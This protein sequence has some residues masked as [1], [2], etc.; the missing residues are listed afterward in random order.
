MIQRIQTIYLLLAFG[1]CLGCMCTTIG[2]LYTPNG[3]A[4]GK[5]FNLW[6]A[7]EDDSRNFMPWA[8]FVIL[9]LT[10]TVI[11]FGIFLFRRRALQMRFTSFTILLLV[12]WYAVYA[13][14]AYMLTSDSEVLFRPSWTAAL[15]A[16][17]IILLLLAF[18]GIH[19]DEMLVRSL[20]RL[21]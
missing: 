9:L 3:E 12:G 4:V 6:I 18:K 2:F 5:M 20:D 17:S 13:L 10:C 1:L 14:F 15:P 7:N 19:K 21:R 8:L 16:V 11:F